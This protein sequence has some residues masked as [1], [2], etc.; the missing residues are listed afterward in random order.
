MLFTVCRKTSNTAVRLPSE[1]G[2]I[3]AAETAKWAKVVRAAN[4]KAK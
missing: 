2:T 1:F 3:I 4:I